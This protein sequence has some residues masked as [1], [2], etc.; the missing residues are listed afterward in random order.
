MVGNNESM[1]SVSKDDY[2]GIVVKNKRTSM[3]LTLQDVLYIPK[4]MVN[5]FSLTKSL[6]TTYDTLS[7]IVL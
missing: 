5:L 1:S 4:L 2:K 6:G 7:S 3:D